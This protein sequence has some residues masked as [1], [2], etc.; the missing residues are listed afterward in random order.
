MT[1]TEVIV[2]IIVIA[3]LIGV[4]LPQ[5]ARVKF[6]ARQSL[7]KNNMRRM[8]LGSFSEP[9]LERFKAARPDCE[10]II[11]SPSE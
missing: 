5:I 3:I 10:V 6:E 4:L 8:A 1:L 2:V 9:G 7:L 11:E